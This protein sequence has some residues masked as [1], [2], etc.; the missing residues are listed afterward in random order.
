MSNHFPSRTDRRRGSMTVEFALTFP[1]LLLLCLG[2]G[3]FGRLFVHGITI[4]HAA[5]A[6]S[7]FG[8]LSN[9]NSGR[10]TQMQS[11]ATNDTGDIDHVNTVSAVADRYCD[12]PD[13]PAAGPSDTN[14]VSC[15]AGSCAG[16]GLPRVFVRTRVQQNFEPVAPIPG[17]P[18]LVDVNRRA[19]LRVQ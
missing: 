15:T 17:I 6:G 11:Q 18:A 7:L 8:S 14:A 5:S 12:C 4:S 2:V 19:Y 9:I 3:D 13:N 1:L 16:Y 10:F